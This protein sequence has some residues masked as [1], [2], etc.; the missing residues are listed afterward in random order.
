VFRKQRV[1]AATSNY[2]TY[3]LNVHK[4]VNI[5]EAL[6]AKAPIS[7]FKLYIKLKEIIN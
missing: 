5:N 3:Y 6:K 1:N 2:K 7:K 4:S